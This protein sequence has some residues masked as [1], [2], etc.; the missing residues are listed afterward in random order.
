M[1][2]MTKE[3]FLENLSLSLNGKVRTAVVTENVNYYEDYINTEMRK[4]KSEEAVLETLG[5]PRLIAKTIVET[6]SHTAGTGEDGDGFF[7]E[8]GARGG[9]QEYGESGEVRRRGLRI[10]LWVWFVLAI[11]VVV[12]VISAVFSIVSAILPVLLPILLV[13]FLVKLFRDWVN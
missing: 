1:E 7:S 6:S 3:E 11:I 8:R 10:P 4:G 2:L 12:L 5:D 9:A 13:V